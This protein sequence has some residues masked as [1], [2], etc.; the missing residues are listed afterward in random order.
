M[1]FTCK[2]RLLCLCR[3]EF[4]IPI[5]RSVKMLGLALVLNIGTTSSSQAFFADLDVTH[6]YYYGIYDLYNEN[7]IEGYKRGDESYFRPTQP[8]T[9]AAAL[10]ILVLAAKYSTNVDI[11][12]PFPDVKEDWYRPYVLSAYNEEIVNGFNDGYFYPGSN[13]TRAEFIKMSVL[14]YKLDVPEKTNDQAWYEPYFEIAKAMNIVE[15]DTLP[16]EKIT[17][18]EVAEIA[19]RSKLVAQTQAPYRFNGF[20]K[21]SYY[22]DRFHGRGTAS[23]ETYD[24]N[25]LTAAHRTLPFG[26][27]LKV[28]YQ[29]KSVIV[30]VNDR[31]PYHQD[32]IL[33]LSEEAFKRLSGTGAGVL[34][35]DFEVVQEDQENIIPE[36]VRE[37][38][39]ETIRT[40]SVPTVVAQKISEIKNQKP[41]KPYY[42]QPIKSLP[43]DFFANLT[44]DKNLP[45]T[46]YQG[47]VLSLSGMSNQD[48]LKTATAFL[49]DSQGEQTTFSTEM[50]G[51]KFNIPVIF[52]NPGKY[53]I[54]IVF[55]EERK[56]R[57]EQV[58]VLPVPTG[59]D[60]YTEKISVALPELEHEI[61]FEEEFFKI[62]LSQ[63]SNQI[64]KVILRQKEQTKSFFIESGVREFKL[65]FH[66]FTSFTP[67]ENIS[68]ALY[69]ADSEN[70]TLATQETYWQVDSVSDFLLTPGFKN[71]ETKGISFFDYQP[72]LPEEDR[73]F[74][75]RKISDVFLKDEVYITKKGYDVYSTP[76]NIDGERFSFNLPLKGAGTYLVEIISNEGE[77]LF[78]K[79]FY[80]S[81][82]VRLLPVYPWQ[83]TLPSYSNSIQKSHVRQWMNDIRS[84]FQ[85]L[86]LVSNPE[87]DR[88]AQDY[89]ER[90]AREDF[91]SHTSPD[92][93][94][95][96]ERTREA[97]LSGDLGENLSLGST[98]ELALM[99]LEDSGSH[100]KNMVHQ[101]WKTVGIGIAKNSEGVYY[102]AQT[103][104]KE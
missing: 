27:R 44:L 10:K 35:V 12:S 74:S 58:E 14:A 39:T 64:S 103:F 96:S 100:L 62:P 104:G 17:R 4:I 83:G 101:K 28:S 13:V 68:I 54:G 61:V 3:E 63:A 5:M 99:G 15:S 59:V 2:E 20:G 23:G 75:G 1:L 19:Y 48:R 82:A 91:I 60:W 41:A 53:Q 11:D 29:D 73:M 22:G 47:S 18:G 52:Q 57:V 81:D 72:F 24:K 88:F 6:P 56:S 76:L 90:M 34:S 89:A 71:N 36:Y 30:R 46:V 85:A 32:R 45:Q 9:R 66:F 43:T 31:G 7:I 42:L 26:T 55:D 97:G 102:F 33:D 93:K 78:N 77:I 98:P 84:Q 21:A 25:D 40:P 86:P 8:I 65:P 38:L 69:K 51:R 37:N 87:L 94:S 92:G 16:H 79:A 80:V 50:N 49:V 67:S 95:F 70:G